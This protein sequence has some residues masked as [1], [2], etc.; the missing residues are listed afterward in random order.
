LG[1]PQTLRGTLQRPCLH[2]AV[3]GRQRY[4][5]GRRVVEVEQGS[6]VLLPERV[7]FTREAGPCAVIAIDCTDTA[8]QVAHAR[9][10]RDSARHVGALRTLDLRSAPLAAF[11]ALGAWLGATP[12]ADP[13]WLAGHAPLLL[14]A[15]AALAHRD[16]PADKSSALGSHRLIRLEEWIDAHLDEPIT[17]GRLCQVAGAGARAPQKDFAERRGMSPMRFV[18]ERRLHA[19]WRKLLD[20]RE[21][22]TVSQIA[23]SVGLTHFGRFSQTYRRAFGEAPSST[24]LRRPRPRHESVVRAT[25]GVSG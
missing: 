12:E 13:A 19:A 20:A 22:D 10:G 2:I 17:M 3:A 16:D 7:E 4:T 18:N 1:L 21:G 9:A 5:V 23:L 25:R 6:A 8:L 14:D 15:L 24:L 11:R